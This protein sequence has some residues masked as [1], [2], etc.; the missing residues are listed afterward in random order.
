MYQVEG[1]PQVYSG[2]ALMAR[3]IMVEMRGDLQAGCCGYGAC[4]AA[5]SISGFFSSLD[6]RVEKLSSHNR[7]F[8][9]FTQAD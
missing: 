6:G 7:S 4:D 2:V 1:E 5:P 3:G 8:G 9:S